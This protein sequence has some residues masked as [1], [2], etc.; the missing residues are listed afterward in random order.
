[1]VLSNDKQ[2]KLIVRYINSE[3]FRRVV[4]EN[5]TW[6]RMQSLKF[7]IKCQKMCDPGILTGKEV[8]LMVYQSAFIKRLS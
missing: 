7:N 5:F 2:D 8:V 6:I 3:V 4:G 1:M